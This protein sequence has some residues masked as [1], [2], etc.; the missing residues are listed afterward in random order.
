[1]QLIELGD[2]LTMSTKLGFQSKL[3]YSTSVAE[4]LGDKLFLIYAPIVKGEIVKFPLGKEYILVFYSQS[5]LYQASGSIL[6]YCIQ[7]KVTLM[8]IEVN[9]FE[10]IQRREFFRVNTT[11]P[12]TYKLL[13]NS[14]A[15]ESVNSFDF[16][17]G[18][19][20]NISGNGLCFTSSEPLQINEHVQCNLSLEIIRITVE[21]VVLASDKQDDYADIY[22]CRAYLVNLHRSHQQEIIRYVMKKERGIILRKQ[23]EAQ[24]KD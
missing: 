3:F 17:K 5:G 24:K 19:V 22:L 11:M 23:I 6:E 10:H 9:E 21:A 4:V 20:K 12:F 14:Q 7:N 13:K 18:V 8:K 1:M 2:N 16:N 15:S